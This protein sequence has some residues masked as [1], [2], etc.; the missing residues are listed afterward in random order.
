[1]DAVNAKDKAKRSKAMTAYSEHQRGL[2]A[3]NRRDKAKRQ[4]AMDA[5]NE[6]QKANR[7]KAIARARKQRQ[8]AYQKQQR[9][10]VNAFI[11]SNKRG[12]NSTRG[13]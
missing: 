7:S 8:R 11:R 9:K 13:H 2:A 1:M 10:T 5:Y 12:R 6:T 4:H 3:A